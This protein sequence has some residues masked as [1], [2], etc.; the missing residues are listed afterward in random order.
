MNM[1]KFFT[2]KGTDSLISKCNY[3]FF[4]FF[5]II[6]FSSGFVLAQTLTEGEEAAIK[7]RTDAVIPKGLR[8][9]ISPKK[10]SQERLYFD[11]LDRQMIFL[12]RDLEA[13][14]NYP[15][16]NDELKRFYELVDSKR[17]S[18]LSE[19]DS[20][21]NKI[22]DEVTERLSKSGLSTIDSD[23]NNLAKVQLNRLAEV[24]AKI[25][26]DAELEK[27]KEYVRQGAGK[28]A[29]YEIEKKIRA[30]E[31]ERQKIVRQAINEA[32]RR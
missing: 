25:L 27:K 19:I 1:I 6:Y 4:A 20:Q 24:R 28:R 26:H 32:N 5:F 22:K 7:I 11:N 29:R 9:V 18:R 21:V 14:D 2:T 16:L 12:R 17:D 31:Y 23:N 8:E 3:L 30:I 13:L 10:R 15:A